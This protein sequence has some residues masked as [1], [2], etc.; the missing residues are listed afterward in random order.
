MRR[1]VGRS[2]AIEFWVTVA[3]F[4]RFPVAPDVAVV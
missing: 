2:G 4:K 3:R 1:G